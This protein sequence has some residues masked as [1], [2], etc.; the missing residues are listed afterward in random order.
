MSGSDNGRVRFFVITGRRVED[1]HVA[2]G[3]PR[4][5][6][7]LFAAF[8]MPAKMLREAV[9]QVAGSR[10]L[11]PARISA[12]VLEAHQVRVTRG[13]ETL[14]HKVGTV[15][16]VAVVAAGLREGVRSADAQTVTLTSSPKYA[17]CEQSR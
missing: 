12:A 9:V 3:D 4:R 14:G 16:A 7:Q 2:H 5:G 15:A 1:G 10:L 17:Y 8:A 13:H 6:F 11:A